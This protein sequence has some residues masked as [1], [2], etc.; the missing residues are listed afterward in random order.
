MDIYQ[1]MYDEL[2]RT[3][4]VFPIII[5][6]NWDFNKLEKYLKTLKL[7]YLTS[8]VE[9]DELDICGDYLFHYGEDDGLHFLY[10][11]STHSFTFPSRINIFDSNFEFSIENDDEYSNN[12][13]IIVYQYNP[14][15]YTLFLEQN[16]NKRKELLI[17][18][19]INTNRPSFIS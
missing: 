5:H 8:S 12:E 3:N 11:E 14:N 19:L 1:Q 9:L 15:L 6:R 4:M 16:E 7:Q 18:W 17:E 13:I 2:L 10:S